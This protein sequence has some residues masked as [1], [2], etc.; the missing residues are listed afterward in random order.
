MIRIKDNIWGRNLLQTTFLGRGSRWNPLQVGGTSLEVTGSETCCGSSE[1]SVF[2]SWSS[3]GSFPKNHT[4]I[5]I[6]SS[7]FQEE[8]RVKEHL[9]QLFMG[10]V[11]MAMT[12]PREPHSVTVRPVH[13]LQQLMAIRKSSFWLKRGQCHT[14]FCLSSEEERQNCYLDFLIS[15][16]AENFPFIKCTFLTSGRDEPLWSLPASTSLCFCDQTF[17]R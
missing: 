17:L 11:G 4:I 15:P 16:C 12:M 2:N 7:W 3:I 13:H 8:D 1:S 10:I 9:S 14:H 5:I 6:I